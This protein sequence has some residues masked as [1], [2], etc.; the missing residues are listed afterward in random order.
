MIAG[1]PYI[2]GRTCEAQVLGMNASASRLLQLYTPPSFP[3]LARFRMRGPAAFC[4]SGSTGLRALSCFAHLWDCRPY[5]RSSFFHRFFLEIGTFCELCFRAYEPES[6]FT[7]R[8]SLQM[9]CIGF[10]DKLSFMFCT[11][12][13]WFFVAYLSNTKGS[14]FRHG[15]QFV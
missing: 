5:H 2:E 7:S 15:G 8:L 11:A 14:S 1:G 12:L 4:M 10:L 3:P 13:M 9:Q 6:L